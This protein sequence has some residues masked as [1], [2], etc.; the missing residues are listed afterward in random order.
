MSKTGFTVRLPKDLEEW[1]AD[2]ADQNLRSRNKQLEVIL[3]NVQKNET[4]T[5]K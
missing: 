1:L 3:R 2:L 5:Q 4:P